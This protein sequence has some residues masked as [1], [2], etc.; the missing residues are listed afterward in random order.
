MFVLRRRPL[1]LETKGGGEVA[2]TTVEEP[3][4]MAAF[5]SLSNSDSTL[6]TYFDFHLKT[7]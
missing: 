3:I 6:E 2:P 4:D 1:L 7:C 5:E